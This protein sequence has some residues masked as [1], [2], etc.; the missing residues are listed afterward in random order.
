MSSPGYVRRSETF[1]PSYGCV[2]KSFSF[3]AGGIM[4]I[5]VQVTVLIVSFFLLIKGAD[6]FVEGSSSLARRLKIPSLIIGLT[7]VAFGTSAPELAV[8][9]TAAIHGSNEI[10]VSNVLGSNIFNNLVVLGI[11]AII[12]PIPVE[13]KVLKRDI[14]FSIII[15]ALLFIAACGGT[16][17][18]GHVSFRHMND[19]AGIITRVIGAVFLLLFALYVLSLIRSAHDEPETDEGE[20][21]SPIWK[22]VLLILTGI[23]M[24]I[25]GG[26]LAV[27]SAEEIAR[28][29]GMSETL[30][31]LT[32]VAAGTSLPELVTSVVA[33]RKG[34]VKLA[35]GNAVG[36]NIFNILL[37]L[38]ISSVIHS[39][40]LTAESVIDL[41]VLIGISIM[42]LVFSASG[43]RINR[44]EGA[45]MVLSYTA[46]V[47]FA[48]IR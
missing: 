1:T 27:Y 38:G 22:C 4:T 3:P 44:V 8:S 9:T 30:I 2:E 48:A 16:L 40:P 31:G 32:I 46:Y 13:K 45:V 7:I 23:A 20:K 18:S 28:A 41:F 6:I 11:C 37:I 34:E 26:K 15:T 43:K 10:A 29:C 33:A 35:I 14:P 12:R 5:A 47:A 36:S 17:V 24:I 42:T 39:I 19:M 21:N 25:L